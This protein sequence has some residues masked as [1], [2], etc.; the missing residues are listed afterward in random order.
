[1]CS[2]NSSRGSTLIE[3]LVAVLVLSLGLL[4]A[5]KLQTEGV[6][7]NANSRYTVLASTYAHD[8]LD[9]ISYD[10]KGEKASWEIV[11]KTGDPASVSVGA[12]RDWMTRLVADL[13]AGAAQITKSASDKTWVVKIFWTPPGETDEARATYAIRE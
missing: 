2:R 13:P 1:M 9:A 5:L 6:R 7:Q 4:G 8:A 11:T 12:P 10:R 3:V